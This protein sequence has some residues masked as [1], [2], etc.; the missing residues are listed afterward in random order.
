LGDSFLTSTAGVSATG[1]ATS[2]LVVAGFLT[3]SFLTDFFFTDSFFT[4]SF[5][6]DSLR[7]D[8]LGCLLAGDSFF[9]GDSFLGDGTSLI[10]IVLATDF[11]AETL[12]PVPGFDTD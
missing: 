5:L 3:D 12:R 7:A 2:F 10:S 6:T 4:D 8:T 9:D 11:L 1:S